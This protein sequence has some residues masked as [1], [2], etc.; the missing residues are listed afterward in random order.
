MTDEPLYNIG[1]V[2]RLTGISIPTL[3]AWERRYDFPHSARTAGGHRLYSEKD[4]ALLRHVRVQIDQG[5]STRQAVL[6]VRRMDQEGRLPL[7]QAPEQ[8]RPTPVGEGTASNFTEQLLRALLQHDLEQAD[9]V[10]AELLAF[11]PPEELA[12]R[13]I[14]PAL[15]AIGEAWER[16]QISVATEHLASNYL[17][18]RLLMWMVTGPRTRPVNPIVLACA[19]DEWHEGSLLMLG[20]LLRRRG[21]P[22]AYLGQN[23]PF[24]DLAS[25]V[26]QI[27]PSALVLVAMREETARTLV[28]W[29]KWILLHSGRP[30]VVHAG[31]A[32][33]VH[34]ELQGLVPGAY[35]G[36]DLQA[37]LTRLEELL[38]SSS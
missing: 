6:A 3:H 11:L 36:D 38:T 1:V 12:T 14:G 5:L 4:I 27:L 13:T 19:P 35:L 18:H 29:P 16:K 33:V 22:V 31:R 32:F 10:M 23:V 2:T 28:D 9:R 26:Q 25:F 17:R 20:V 24:S 7:V 8:S 34:P 15:A 37:G 30:V 21:W